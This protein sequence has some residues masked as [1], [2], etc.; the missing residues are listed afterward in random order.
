MHIALLESDQSIS[1][2]L[3]KA[4]AKQHEVTTFTRSGDLLH[5]IKKQNFEFYILD[6]DLKSADVLQLLKYIRNALFGREP[7]IFLTT[8]YQE[9]ELVLVLEAGADDYLSKSLCANALSAR[10]DALGRRAYVQFARQLPREINGYSFDLVERAVHFDNRRVLLSA[11]QFELAYYFFCNH[12]RAL[13]RKQLLASVWGKDMT[14]FSSVLSRTLDVHVR[15]LRKNLDLGAEA[16]TVKLLS[17][18]GYGYRL[19]S[20]NR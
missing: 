14:T 9:S 8:N 13:S 17:V 10:I 1:A 12:D 11:K 6:W 18:H 2:C 3:L 5:A 7:V 16:R 4:L 19:V 15:L 20:I